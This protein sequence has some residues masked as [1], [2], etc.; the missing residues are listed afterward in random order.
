MRNRNAYLLAAAIVFA[1]AL[2]AIVGALV[3]YPPAA[4]LQ[5]GDITGTMIRGGA[6]TDTNVS[7]TAQI[8]P[9]KIGDNDPQGQIYFSNGTQFGTSTTL[10]YASSTKVLSVIGGTIA[11]TSTS[12]GGVNQT[13]PGSQCAANQTWTGNDSGVL[14]CTT[15]TSSVVTSAFTAGEAITKGDIVVI[16][17]GLTT[18]YATGA[19]TGQTTHIG[20]TLSA[21]NEIAMSTTSPASNVR[22][23][24]TVDGC[25]RDASPS[26]TAAVQLDIMADTAGSPSGTS[27]GSTTLS[28][29]NPNGGTVRTFTFTTPVTVAVGTTYWFVFSDPTAT[30]Q[31]QYCTNGSS[32]VTEKQSTN[33]GSSWGS[34]TADG[35][36]G[37]VYQQTKTTEVYQANATNADSRANGIVGMAESTVSAGSSVSID[38]NGLSTA[39]TTATAGT[40]YY[41]SNTAGKMGTSAGAQ[42]RKLGIGLGSLGFL[43]EPQ[44][45]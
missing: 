42:S 35:S 29:T 16:G 41:L 18:T 9:A 17:T 43:I 37:V 34:G 27:L 30:G 4:L 10:T 13:W 2:P 32:A 11:A 45:P 44:L 33:G 21:S 22:A 3:S 19:Q 1:G 15:L 28:F 39:T 20:S 36:L 23:I 6:I 38:M 31:P 12:F 7:A 24:S 25:F 26:E 8:N 5:P 14:S 40:E